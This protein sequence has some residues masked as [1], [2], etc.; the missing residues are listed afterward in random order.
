MTALPALV[1]GVLLGALAVSLHMTLLHTAIA[2]VAE[3]PDATGR[4]HIL[5]TAPIRVLLWVPVL[6]IVARMGLT[7]CLGALA[8]MLVGRAIWIGRYWHDVS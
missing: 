7:A 1:T 6:F 5:K 4:G 3:A 2:R 8:S